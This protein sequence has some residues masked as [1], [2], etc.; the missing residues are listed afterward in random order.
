[1]AIHSALITL[2]Q[3]HAP[4]A[5]AFRQLRTSLLYPGSDTPLQAVL[6]TSSAPGEGKSGVAANLAI[7]LAQ[8]GRTVVLVDAD[9]RHPTLHTLFDVPAP[10]GLATVLADTAADPT[11]VASGV[12]RLSLLPCGPVPPNPAE[13]LASPRM[14]QVMSALRSQGEFVL[15]DAPPATAVADAVV[16]APQVDG[17]LLVLQAGVSK[18]D[19]VDRAKQQLE[20]VRANLMGVVFTNA[21]KGAG[22]PYPGPAP[23]SRG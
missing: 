3:P 9:L 20:Q 22:A 17:V 6:I 16:L 23:F 12:E 11:P 18:R 2:T 21:P 14:A 4:A 10:Q 13:L 15:F 8:A 7:A 1:M 19:Q 5:E